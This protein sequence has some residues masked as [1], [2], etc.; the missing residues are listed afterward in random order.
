MVKNF[1]VDFVMP[2]V[3]YEYINTDRRYVTAD[4]LALTLNTDNFSP[5]V[6]TDVKE[7]LVVTTMPSF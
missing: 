3:M 7:L 1:D 5:R 4:F 2:F 6:S